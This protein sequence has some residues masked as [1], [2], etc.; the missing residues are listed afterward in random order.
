MV[1][2]FLNDLA[3]GTPD[4]T[5][6]E[7]LEI[8]CGKDGLL[9]WTRACEPG[10]A[11]AS[12]GFV[13][14]A[15][16]TVAG[17]LLRV[18][19]FRQDGTDKNPGMFSIVVDASHSVACRAAADGIEDNLFDLQQKVVA[20]LAAGAQTA[21]DGN[22]T[23]SKSQS[24]E[25]ERLVTKALRLEPRPDNV[26]DDMWEQIT[27]FRHMQAR[28][29]VSEDQ[30]RKVLLQRLVAKA[31][32]SASPAQHLNRPFTQK[33]PES[34]AQDLQEE[35]LRSTQE[36][37]EPVN[38]SLKLKPSK[39]KEAVISE[40]RVQEDSEEV[41]QYSTKKRKLVPIN[42]TDEEKRVGMTVSELQKDIDTKQIEVI[43]RH[44]EDALGEIDASLIGHLH[45]IVRQN[46]T[47]AKLTEEVRE[48]LEEDAANFAA[49]LLS[50]IG[51]IAS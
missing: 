37:A 20:I 16:P 43:T 26:D 27:S 50:D 48:I 1:L 21:R 17:R 39:A 30:K 11:P 41:D 3:K 49:A 36:K 35:P 33:N 38:V 51:K 9:R 29:E 15:D 40:D 13:E 46:A 34:C 47:V 32:S 19:E 25:Y 18:T 2:L 28:Y 24:E 23:K 12:F 22:E 7:A 10:G 45:T 31:R 4:K 8:V 6:Q 44:V 14:C 42:F 5:V